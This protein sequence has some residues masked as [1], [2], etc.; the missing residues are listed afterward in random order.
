MK[1]IRCPHCQ[2]VCGLGTGYYHDEKLNIRC[3]RCHKV[4]LAT[5]EDD[6]RDLQKLFTRPVNESH[7][8]THTTHN[9]Y[10]G[11]AGGNHHYHHHHGHGRHPP[12]CPMAEDTDYD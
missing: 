1:V 5:N 3:N 12:M 6:E 9:N 2:S 7:D 11:Y 4:L 8:H 10:A